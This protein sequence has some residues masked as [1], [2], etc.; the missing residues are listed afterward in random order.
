MARF[1]T[2]IQSNNLT[3]GRRKKLISRKI[4]TGPVTLA[5]ITI[6]L[7]CLLGLFFLA[8]VFQSSTKGYEITDLE[9][10]VEELKEQN[11]LL[12]IKAAELR[13]FENIKSEAEKLNLIPSNEI[14]YIRQSG[15]SVARANQ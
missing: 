12:E 9:K 1:L 14:V 5:I 15:R 11:K 8:Q 6:T 4:R 13:S 2:I 7:V 10:R 3:P